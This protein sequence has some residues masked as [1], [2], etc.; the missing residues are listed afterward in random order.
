[1]QRQAAR[2]EAPC[3]CR[4]Q[5]AVLLFSASLDCR[6]ENVRVLPVIVSEL[7][8]GN[9]E[10][11]IFAAHFVERADHAAFEYRPEAFDGL[12]MNCTDDILAS[13]VV[14]G[15]V[16]VILIEWIV[17]RIL[18]GAKQADFMRDGFADERGESGSPDVRDHARNH[19]A[20]AA[21]GADDWRFAG[22]NATGSAATAA[23]SQ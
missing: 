2:L 21:N 23:L 16:W 13:G 6:S 14:N 20:L 3:P 4:Q 22:T 5:S 10:R 15:G 17:A 19:I 1:M 7:E 12:S 8:L 9:I 18:I 11:H